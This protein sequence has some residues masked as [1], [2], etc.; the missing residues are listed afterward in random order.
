KSDSGLN[1]PVAFPIFGRGRALWALAGAGLNA[2][3]IAEAGTFL[4]GA[5]SCEAKEFNPGVDLLFAADWEAGLSAAPER[6]RL[7]DPLLKPRPPE[8]PA[9]P[10]P[11]GESSGVVLWGALLAVGL[12][13][14]ISGRRVLAASKE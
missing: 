2:Q 6:E 12:L 14:A 3:F 8:P 9:P 11:S 10:A 13:V 5:C 7:P 4:T 1:G